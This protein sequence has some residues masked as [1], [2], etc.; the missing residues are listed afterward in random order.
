MSVAANHERLSR[1]QNRIREYLDT[2]FR[3]ESNNPGAK[4][5]AL[6]HV[7][8]KDETLLNRCQKYFMILSYPGEFESSLVDHIAHLNV[9]LSNL[10]SVVPQE[11]VA[12]PH[13]T[14]HRQ[15]QLVQSVAANVAHQSSSST[16]S[17]TTTTSTTHPSP[18]VAHHP[19]HISEAENYANQLAHYANLLSDDP[20][21]HGPELVNVIRDLRE[22]AY[23]YL[24]FGT[25]HRPTPYAVQPALHNLHHPAVPMAIPTSPIAHVT[26]HHF[27]PTPVPNHA[28]RTPADD[29]VDYDDYVHPEPYSLVPPPAPFHYSSSVSQPMQHTFASHTTNPETGAVTSTASSSAGSVST[30]NVPL[31]ISGVPIRTRRLTAQHRVPAFPPMP[32][33]MPNSL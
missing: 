17:S 13:Q 22:C 32:L 25:P 21:R 8:S 20:E 26:E 28:E 14:S 9:P 10:P 24:R 6:D 23:L 29:L 16:S 7:M 18:P 12:A 11:V 27:G 1:T 33:M 2:K 19:L 15:E 31:S 3:G 4:V 5:R 30:S